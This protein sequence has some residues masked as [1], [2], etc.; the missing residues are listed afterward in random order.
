MVYQY[1]VPPHT[2]VN[3]EYYKSVLDV[4]AKHIQRKRPELHPSGWRLHHDN[5]RPHVCN[6]VTQHLARRNIECVPYPPFSIKSLGTG[7]ECSNK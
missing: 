3:G 6:V 4:L 1:E 2:T 5:A 7:Q